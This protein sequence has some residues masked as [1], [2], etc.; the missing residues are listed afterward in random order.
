MYKVQYHLFKTVPEQVKDEGDQ[1]QVTKSEGWRKY[2]QIKDHHSDD[3]GGFDDE[4]QFID[5]DDS[6]K[7]AGDVELPS[8]HRRS[9]MARAISS[10]D[11]ESVCKVAQ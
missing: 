7:L 6:F 9:P 1:E 2:S 5:E 8:P 10:D 3:E 4:E 11:D